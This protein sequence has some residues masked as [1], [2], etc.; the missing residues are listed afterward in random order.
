MKNNIGRKLTS[1]TLMTIMFAGGMTAAVPSMMPGIFAEGAS[2][3]TGL[4]SVSSTKI[5]GASILEIVI[6]DPAISALDTA[7]G[8]PT[9]TFDGTGLALKPAQ[10]TDG[11]WYSYIVDDSKSALADAFNGLNF[12]TDCA[13]TLTFAD[14]ATVANSWATN[15]DLCI[16]PYGPD[17]GEGTATTTGVNDGVCDNVVAPSPCFR[18]TALNPSSE[19]LNDAPALNR[20]SNANNG[21]IYA[22]L[23]TTASSAH[24]AW[25]FI[26]QVTMASDN[27]VTY[28][29]ETVTFEWGNTNSDISVA[30]D[31]D[32]Y[33]DGADMNLVITDPGLN[34]DP[35]TADKWVFETLTGAATVKRGFA[36]GTT[37]TSLTSL[38]TI[39]FGDASTVV[40]SGDTAAFCTSVTVEET[41]DATGVFASVGTN[42]SSD[43][44][45][46][47]APVNHSH[48]VFSYGGE[49]ASVHIAFHNADISFD[50]GDAW[51]PAEA[52]TVTISDPDANRVNGYDEAMAMNVQNAATT[53]PYIQMGTP[54]Y[55]GG[56]DDGTEVEGWT[57]PTMYIQGASD[58]AGGG[59]CTMTASA[60]GE[61]GIYECASTVTVGASTVTVVDIVTDYS[62]AALFNRTG[63]L[64][65]NYDISSVY[66][67]L[68]A[69]S[70]VVWISDD[71]IHY[72][73]SPGN[74]VL[75][76]N[77]TSGGSDKVHSGAGQAIIDCCE[78]ATGGMNP[79]HGDGVD[80]KANGNTE[81][82]QV[83]FDLIHPS[84]VVAAATYPVAV[85][86]FNFN[87]T[88]DIANAIYRLEAEEDGTDGVFTGTV[89]Y[90]TMVHEGNSTNATNSLSANGDAITLLLAGDK[91]GASAP[92]INYGDKD[93]SNNVSS[94]GAQLDANT[95]SG[96]VTFDSSNYGADS[97]V[98]VT[99]NDPDLN[100]DSSA[101]ESYS[102]MKDS[103]STTANEGYTFD[104]SYNDITFDFT[105]A[106]NVK[107]VE[108]GAD[109][110]VFVTQFKTPV[111]TAEQSSGVFY[112]GQDLKFSYYD[113]KDASGTSVTT[114]ASAEQSTTLGSI[115]LDRAVYP[116][117]F[118]VGWLSSGNGD[119]L[120][121][122][123]AA[124]PTPTVG[125][126]SSA[127]N[128]TVYFTVTDPDYTGET[129]NDFRDIVRIKLNGSVIATAG[130][131]SAQPQPETVRRDH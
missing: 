60:G 69:S 67:A 68:N 82:M 64:V 4:V 43:C 44:D 90:A 55:L 104:V 88:T 3:A 63:T 65:L 73:I 20:N 77:V 108:T 107:L 98:H 45:T 54:L 18:G 105:A 47:A 41:G 118:N 40:S 113:R 13:A 8:Q 79:P 99:V 102:A 110:G 129:I 15:S 127:G 6:D 80:A 103:A 115:S 96:T 75:N 131:T 97:I 130:G 52:A 109:T 70:M 128:V 95:H 51:M 10:A 22:T 126:A 24:S 37:G 19:V 38:D 58:T 14:G 72:D 74:A 1:L 94:I 85:D 2:S 92:R 34:I 21:Q 30:F 16:Q 53:I 50:A 86:I 5:Q 114:Y 123:F 12:G 49:S 124:S 33:A 32:T 46:I 91:T 39:D 89:D 119:T 116:V 87:S 7:I 31:P 9:L 106:E 101:R 83:H 11:K 121:N 48:G 26:E 17:A 125:A 62:I 61:P 112:I 84:S 71:N 36:N 117:P 23:N 120:D 56:G 57:A 76:I 25:P 35:T 111:A 93:E 78:G 59:V 27:S 42:G 29:G 100:H 66:D 122:V 28:G 81:G